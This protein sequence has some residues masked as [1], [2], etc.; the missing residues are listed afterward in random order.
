MAQAVRCHGS[1]AEGSVAT[2]E[3]L[4]ASELGTAGDMS[5]RQR[6]EAGRGEAEE[7]VKSALGATQR[8]FLTV[9]TAESLEVL[10]RQL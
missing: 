8:G 7:E 10:L 2:E 3:L 9:R 1:Q 5:W 6:L 4:G